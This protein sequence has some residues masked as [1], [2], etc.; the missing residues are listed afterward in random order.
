MSWIVLAFLSALLLGCYDIAKKASVRNNAVPAV[1]LVNVSTAAIFWLGPIGYSVACSLSG[2]APVTPTGV[3][4]LIALAPH[5]HG[6]LF[7]KSLLVGCSWICAF[8]ALKH[9]PLSIASPIRATS[10]LWTIA[11]AVLLMGERPAPL[12]WLGIAVVIVA[13]LAFSRVGARE[14][15]HFHRDRWVVLMM[16]GTLLGAASSLYDKYLLQQLA[17]PPATVQAWFSVYLVPVMLPL[18]VRWYSRER[19]RVPFEWR[20]TIPLIAIT[21]L[22]ADYAYFVAVSDPNA[23]ISVISPVRRSAVVIPFLFGVVYCKE[24]NWH[25]KAACITANLT[26]VYLL[27]QAT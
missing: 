15:I 25:L 9:L 7:L 2:T 27:S 4:Q 6:L 5:E 3:H 19:E 1:L 10:P 22:A 16:I 12:Q 18:A 17:I 11:C 13:F 14:G 26:G 20:P 21:L 24:P 23:L 8:L